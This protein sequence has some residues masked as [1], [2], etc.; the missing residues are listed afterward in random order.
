MLGAQECVDLRRAA[1]EAEP[2]GSLAVLFLH[3][4]RGGSK[5]G[6]K[7]TR[8]RRFAAGFGAQTANRASWTRIRGSRLVGIR[9]Q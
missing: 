8:S 7:K 3:P 1:L 5:I 4:I 6:P 9:P 2:L